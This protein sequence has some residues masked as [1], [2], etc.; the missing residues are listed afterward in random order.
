MRVLPVA[1][2]ILASALLL[3]ACEPEAPG[4]GEALPPADA[5]AGSEVLPPSAESP[6][7]PQPTTAIDP[8]APFRRDFVLKG[9]EPFWNLDVKDG[10]LILTR[11]DEPQLRAPKAGLAASSGK[12]I[13]TAQAI[14]TTIIATVSAGQCSDGMSDRTYPYRAEVKVGADLI[15]KGCGIAAEDYATL[16]RP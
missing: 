12:A 8:A 15:L 5:P 11:P 2:L 7:Q 6:G 13:W 9:T 1:S 4:G 3:T 14:E 10:A 16:P